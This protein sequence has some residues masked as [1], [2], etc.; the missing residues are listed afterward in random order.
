VNAGRSRYE[1]GMT[2]T[3]LQRSVEIPRMLEYWAQLKAQAE[4]RPDG[5]LLLQDHRREVGFVGE[6]ELQG[7]SI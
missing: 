4:L 1:P 7:A 3:E 2:S 5:T 6:A